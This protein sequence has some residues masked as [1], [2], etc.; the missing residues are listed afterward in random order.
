M[1][2]PLDLFN[3]WW[4]S[5]FPLA[6]PHQQHVSNAQYT[7]V[8][9]DW[10]SVVGASLSSDAAADA[11]QIALPQTKPFDARW[12]KERC[13]ELNFWRHDR[14]TTNTSSSLF[15]RVTQV[16]RYCDVC[17]PTATDDPD[18]RPSH[19]LP[20]MDCLWDRLL[21]ECRANG[22][23]GILITGKRN[24]VQYSSCADQSPSITPVLTQFNGHGG[25]VPVWFFTSR[26]LLMI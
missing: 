21:P 17:L 19:Q 1:I 3:C 16:Q 13:K 9:I 10:P 18:R 4:S 2:A 5:P 14:Q 6:L 12:P 20:L 7:F 24:F 15:N 11:L 25:P 22:P 8:L 26:S 23:Q